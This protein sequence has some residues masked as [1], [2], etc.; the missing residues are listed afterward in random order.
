MKEKNTTSVKC[1][2]ILSSRQEQWERRSASRVLSYRST[3]NLFTWLLR[4]HQLRLIWEP[5]PGSEK[6][7]QSP[8]KKDSFIRVQTLLCEDCSKRIACIIIW[9]QF[10][11]MET[12]PQLSPSAEKT[13]SVRKAD[14]CHMRVS[15]L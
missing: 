13:S 4:G 15:V 11:V 14:S 10:T 7:S 12:G 3:A 6:D 9:A 8:I 2:E 1:I 5:L